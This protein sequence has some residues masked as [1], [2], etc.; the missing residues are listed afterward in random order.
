MDLV[1]SMLRKVEAVSP[2]L[3]TETVRSSLAAQNLEMEIEVIEMTRPSLETHS[4]LMDQLMEAF[5]MSS[6]KYHASLASL[7]LSA[8]VLMYFTAM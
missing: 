8:S 4:P 2:S 3:M 1:P 6:G 7:S 5:D